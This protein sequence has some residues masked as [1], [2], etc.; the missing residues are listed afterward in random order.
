MVA[1]LLLRDQVSIRDHLPLQ[2]L[3]IYL[4]IYSKMMYALSLDCAVTPEP[5]DRKISMMSVAVGSP[6]PLPD[7]PADLFTFDNISFPPPPSTAVIGENGRFPSATAAP[8]IHLRKP[9]PP[10]PQDLNSFST[11]E[12]R[13]IGASLSDENLTPPPLPKRSQKPPPR[14]KSS[15]KWTPLTC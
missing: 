9:I 14:C 12:S 7:R 11:S 8:Q 13:Q 10:P 1:G 6:P 4:N 3:I 15:L 2:A 5:N